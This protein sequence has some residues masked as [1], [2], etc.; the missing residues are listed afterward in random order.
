MEER[1]QSQRK[2]GIIA[3]YCWSLKKEDFFKNARKLGK[4]AF[5]MIEIPMH[6]HCC[7]VNKCHFT[8]YISNGVIF[9]QSSFVFDRKRDKD[10]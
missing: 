2:A 4:R 5:F 6:P 10:L 3:D 8:D 7:I 9:Q 1:Y